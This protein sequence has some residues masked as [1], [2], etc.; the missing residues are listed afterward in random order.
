MD[1]FNAK[2]IAAATGSTL[3]ALTSMCLWRCAK[4][5]SDKTLILVTPFDV[6]KTRLQTQP[7]AR[8]QLFPRPPFP[9]TCCQPN[10]ALGCVRNMSSYARSIPQ[11]VVCIWDHG[12]MRTERV[13]GFWDAVRHVARA[14]GL[15]G[16]WKGAGTTLC[17]KFSFDLNKCIHSFPYVL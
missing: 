1:P 3:T 14:E 17:V 5:V 6:V 2:L 8:S 10:N 12:M 11:E 4:V 15:R 16:L 13:T 9:Q 7:P